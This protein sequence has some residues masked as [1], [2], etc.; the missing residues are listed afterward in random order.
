M[1]KEIKKTHGAKTPLIILISVIILFTI[2]LFL[3]AFFG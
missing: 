2:I 1:E 3:K